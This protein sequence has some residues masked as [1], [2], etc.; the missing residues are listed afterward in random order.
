MKLRT[1]AI[2]GLL[3]ALSAGASS[4]AAGAVST[5]QARQLE[6][7]RPATQYK[8]APTRRCLRGRGAL[9]TPIRARDGRLKELADLA[10]KTSFEVR[11]QKAT[12]GMAFGNSRL[13]AE[14]LLVPGNRHRFERRANVLLVYLP[15][16][17]RVAAL[18]R[19][20]LRR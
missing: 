6:S 7:A 2:A 12:L 9:V 10:Q 4:A 17:R 19:G 13:L 14:L 16:A 15:S 18:V 20:C 5:G 11:V 8:L 1:L 3:A